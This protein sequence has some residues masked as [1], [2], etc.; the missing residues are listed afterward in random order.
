MTIGIP[1]KRAISSCVSFLVSTSPQ[2]SICRSC[3]I[4]APQNWSDCTQS[5]ASDGVDTQSVRFARFKISNSSF[6]FSS[7]VRSAVQSVMPRPSAS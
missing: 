4:S 5:S 2:N 6:G 1:G 3:G 7:A